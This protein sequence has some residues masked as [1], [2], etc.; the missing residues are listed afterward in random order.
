MRF[1]GVVVLG[2]VAIRA[3]AMGAISGFTVGYAKPVPSSLPPVP[4]TQ[5]PPLPP[6]AA[7]APMQQAAQPVAAPQPMPWPVPYYLPVYASAPAPTPASAP[8]PPRPEW[9]LPDPDPLSVYPKLPSL[10][11]S[12]PQQLALAG[13]RGAQSTPLPPVIGG[14]TVRPKLDRWQLTT[15]ALLRGTSNPDALATGGTLGG[16]QGGA[17]LSYFLNRSL[18]ASLRMTSPIGGSR[19][20]EIAAGIR[21]APFQSIPIAITAERRQSISRFGGRSDFALLVEGGV[22]HSPMPLDFRLDA[23]GQ[24]GVVGLKSRDI[25]AD[26]ALA[27]TRPVYG[28]FS[29]GFGVWGG[30]QPGLY[31]VDAGPRISMRLRDN[32]YAH[33]DWRQR[34]AGAASPSSGP[35]LTVAADF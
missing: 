15:W 35:A 17:R 16:S 10:N 18:A 4:R 14:K 27:F 12:E 30:Y 31:R 1:L 29:A 5:F 9:R 19:G 2:W 13:F 24:A 33:L 6:V 25:F 8:I 34:I 23:Y 11:A 28:R 7:P 22:Y 3:T 26:G 20:A 32:I 21:W